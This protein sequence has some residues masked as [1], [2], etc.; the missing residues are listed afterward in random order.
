MTT[1]A[2]HSFYSEMTRN[3]TPHPSP[4]ASPRTPHPAPRHS[5]VQPNPQ[6]PI[7]NIPA[8][9]QQHTL[10]LHTAGRGRATCARRARLAHCQTLAKRAALAEQLNIFLHHVTLLALSGTR[11]F[12]HHETLLSGAFEIATYDL[13]SQVGKVR[14]VRGGHAALLGGAWHSPNL[15]ARS[16]LPHPNA[17]SPEA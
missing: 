6:K 10:P 17:T 8:H 15:P 14:R 13:A 11:C 9:T 16:G 7:K 12:L 1:L 5:R 4:L 3:I 2:T